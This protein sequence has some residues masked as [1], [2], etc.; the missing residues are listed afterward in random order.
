MV[1]KQILLFS[2][3]G[4][5]V[6]SLIVVGG[7]LVSLGFFQQSIIE[8]TPEKLT[9]YDL[10]DTST[11]DIFQLYGRFRGALVEK[12]SNL[13]NFPQDPFSA[14]VT[15][16]TVKI[17]TGNNVFTFITKRYSSGEEGGFTTTNAG[18]FQ[19]IQVLKNGNKI[20]TIVSDDRE[21]KSAEKQKSFFED[22]TQDSFVSVSMVENFY[23]GRGQFIQGCNYWKNEYNLKLPN[24]AFEFDISVPTQTFIEGEEVM[25]DVKVDNKLSEKVL[26]D[27]SITFEAPTLFGFAQKTLIQETELNPGVNNLIFTLKPE[28]AEG[29]LEII[30]SVKVSFLGSNFEGL[31]FGTPTHAFGF[32]DIGQACSSADPCSVYITKVPPKINPDAWIPVG[33]VRG[34]SELVSI[35]PRP[36]YLPLEGDACPNEYFVNED[37]TFCIRDDVRDL[38]CNIIGCPVIGG[39]EYQCTS[40]GICAETIFVDR[41]CTSDEMCNPNNASDLSCDIDSGL[42]IKSQIFKEVIQCEVAGDCP[43]I[44]DGLVA[45]CSEQNKC[46]YSGE[47]VVQQFGCN[48]VGCAEGFTCNEG[49]NICEAPSFFDKL[50]STT[51]SIFLG[52]GSLILIIIIVL[53]LLIRKR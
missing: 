17:N 28:T 50:T 32:T 31:N 30:P 10:I 15:T 12:R 26:A 16:D 42:C 52:V 51:I 36:L 43:A 38:T 5:M 13:N 27:V 14:S 37:K 41:S 1:S 24:D 25:V 7:L 21:G 40:A 2:I 4:L 22:E 23:D 29:T 44:C 19:E 8:I 3:I 9:Q 46:T 48:Q 11:G 53:A 6:V 49:K 45:S 20:D 47:C 34:D 39:V 35:S 33:I 18:C